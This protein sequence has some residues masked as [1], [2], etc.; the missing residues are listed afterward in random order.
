MPAAD[1]GQQEGCGEDA[2]CPGTG[3]R[4]AQTEPQTDQKKMDQ[5]QTDQKQ[6]DQKQ[7]TDGVETDRMEAVGRWKKLSG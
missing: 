3:R 7:K 1:G 2:D 5:K 4:R 6:T